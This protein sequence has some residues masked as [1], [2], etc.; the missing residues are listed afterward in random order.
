MP[1]INFTD[2]EVQQAAAPYNRYAAAGM[3]VHGVKTH[4]ANGLGISTTELNGRLKKAEEWGLLEAPRNIPDAK[5]LSKISFDNHK[6]KQRLRLL[7][8]SLTVPQHS[9]K[10]VR[11][12]AIGDAHDAPDLPKDRFAWMGQLANAEQP[13]YIVQIGDFGTFDS[14]NTHMPNDTLNGKL[15][16]P[17]MRDVASLKEALAVF[18]AQIKYQPK[19]HVTLGNH[20]HRAWKYEDTNPEVAGML[21]H[22]I[23]STFEGAGWA[24]SEYGAWHFIEGVGFHHAPFHGGGQP[25]RQ[26][27]G[28]GALANKL[29]FDAVSGHTHQ[30]QEATHAKYGP[31][32]TAVNLG[33]ALPW[34][35]IA[36]YARHS[37]QAWWWGCAIITIQNGRIIETQWHSMETLERKYGK[38]RKQRKKI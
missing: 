10:T 32:V 7:S 18:N 25:M 35:Y 3:I 17:F 26:A 9:H 20:E 11:V 36:H 27:P 33:C 38:S 15:K 19:K 21:Q 14:L 29:T 8:A 23:T 1:K 5:Q 28:M 2:D 13:E 4:I 31:A 12:L 16:P 6:E 22:Q 30:K 34:G 24:W 37:L